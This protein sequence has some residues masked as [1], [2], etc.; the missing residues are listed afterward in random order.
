MRLRVPERGERGAA[1]VEFA[2][3]L[4]LVVLFVFGIVEFGRA[5]SARIQLDSAV[6]EGARAAALGGDTTAVST[7]TKNAATGLNPV[8]I[9]VTQPTTCPANPAATDNA[10]VQASYPFTY[11]IPFW[12]TGTW[13]LQA[14]GVMRCGG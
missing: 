12:G 8:S 5:Y 3:V 10:T 7:A 11:D 2:I 9:T 6:R 1:V 14:K 4:P 13:T